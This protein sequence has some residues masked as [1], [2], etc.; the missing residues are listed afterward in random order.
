MV[1]NSDISTLTLPRYVPL[2]VKGPSLAVWFDSQKN[3]FI[4]LCPQCR[5]LVTYQTFDIAYREMVLSERKRCQGCRAKISF[6]KA[7]RLIGVF[8]DFWRRTGD[9]PESA[10]W[11]ETYSREESDL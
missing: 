4:V 5:R 6:E 10:A 2:V 1:G 11:F 3:Q 9:L 8:F 7:P